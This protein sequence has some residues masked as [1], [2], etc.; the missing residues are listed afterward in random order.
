M[1]GFILSVMPMLGNVVN[2]LPETIPNFDAGHPLLDG[3][4]TSQFRLDFPHNFTT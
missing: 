2:A 3:F 1:G 4:F